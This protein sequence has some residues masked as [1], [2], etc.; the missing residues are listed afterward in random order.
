MVGLL[1]L[2]LLSV[3]DITSV[4][5]HVLGVTLLIPLMRVQRRFM[6]VRP[7]ARLLSVHPFH[8][9]SEEYEKNETWKILID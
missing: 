8:L 5:C 3:I 2:P 7:T 6:S 9:I 4:V 1:S